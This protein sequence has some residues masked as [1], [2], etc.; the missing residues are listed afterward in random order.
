MYIY[1]IE[2]IY[3]HTYIH[4][5]YSENSR[6]LWPSLRDQIEGVRFQAMIVPRQSSSALKRSSSNPGAL[7][8]LAKR[9]KVGETKI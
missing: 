8:E 9:R 1:K 4:P 7:G 6:H 5:C 3:I 2:Y